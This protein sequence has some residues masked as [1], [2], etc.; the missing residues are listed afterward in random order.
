MKITD[1]LMPGLYKPASNTNRQD[2][3]FDTLV[4][5][6]VKE[7]KG[8]DYYL[9]HQ[10]QLEQSGLT[11]S[12]M[13]IKPVN[14]PL[15]EPPG[16]SRASRD[17]QPDSEIDSRPLLNNS[18]EA[19]HVIINVSNSTMSPSGKVST[20][21]KQIYEQTILQLDSKQ[22]TTIQDNTRAPSVNANPVLSNTI[23]FKNH[24]LFID[25]QL[26]EVTLN[27]TQLS[28]DET[29]ALQQLVKQWLSRKG[30][31]LKQLI[32]NGDIQ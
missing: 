28:K 23:S 18:V 9:Q 27:T 32:I 7:S 15:T 17:Y 4:N 30:L 2:V 22:Q 26:A 31:V 25:N 6:P 14:K 24:Q 12:P 29:K 13:I 3:F 20:T 8:D 16:H 10:T 5:S 11:F 19:E 21:V 1:Q